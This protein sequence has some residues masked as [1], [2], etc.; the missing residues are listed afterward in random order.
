MKEA[1]VYAES[2]LVLGILSLYVVV[3]TVI[4]ILATAFPEKKE[5]SS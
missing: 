1:R 5:H 4:S 2:I 3:A